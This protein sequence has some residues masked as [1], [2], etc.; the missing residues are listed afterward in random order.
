MPAPPDPW[1][2]LGVERTA[3]PEAIR[4]AYRTRSQL[5]HPDL[6]EGRPEAVRR[7][8][9]RAMAQ[10]TDAYHA[11]RDGTAAGGTR[12]RGRRRSLAYLVGRRI[13]RSLR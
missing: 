13:G 1:A 7:E 6:H 12:G 2:V 9:Q 3:G 5:L 11:V 8:A 10:L 4:A